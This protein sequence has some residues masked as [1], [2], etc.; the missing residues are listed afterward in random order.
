MER[1]DYV[2]GISCKHCK[3]GATEE[4]KLRFQER[5]KQIELAEKKGMKHIHDAKEETFKIKGY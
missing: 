1:E 4:Q 3:D 2:K 5:Q